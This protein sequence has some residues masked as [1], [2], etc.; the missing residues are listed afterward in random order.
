MEPLHVHYEFDTGP[1]DAIEV[2]L[3]GPAN[4]S[5]LDP[6]NYRA[7]LDGREFHY[8]GGYVRTSPYILRPSRT[9]RW[10]VVVDLGGYAGTIRAAA[11]VV[12]GGRAAVAS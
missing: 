7:Y 5:L 8:Q 2:T 12:P 3:E 11:R 10:H 9:G 6:P 4:V 1:D